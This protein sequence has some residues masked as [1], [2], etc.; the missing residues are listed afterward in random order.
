[1]V[2]WQNI[3][4]LISKLY[5]STQKQTAVLVCL[6]MAFVAFFYGSDLISSQFPCDLIITEV[7]A[8]RPASPPVFYLPH[9]DGS[10][11]VRWSP[12]GTITLLTEGF[13][14]AADP[15]VSYNGKKILFAGKRQPRD[16]WN[17]WEMDATG[18]NKRQIT[19][20]LGDCIEPKYLG[21]ISLT[22][23]K[24][25]DRTRWVAF[26]STS[27]EAYEELA[28]NC[29][30]GE[31]APDVNRQQTSALYIQNL[32]AVAGQNS[33]TR[34]LTY[35]L[36]SDFSLCPLEDG[37]ILYTSH[38][39]W[40]DGQHSAG[41]FILMAC[42][43]DGAGAHILCGE[44][45]VSRMKTM[46]CEMPDHT[47][48]FVESERALTEE[49]GSLARISLKHPWDS[50]ESLS[51]PGILYLHPH[52]LPDGRLLVACSVNYK[53]MGIVIF[54]FEKRALEQTIVSLPH[55]DLLEAIPLVPHPEP[56]GQVASSDWSDSS[57]VLFCSNVYDSN[58][59][60]S[61]FIK[62]GD[63]THVRLLEGVSQTHPPDLV[64][65]SMQLTPLPWRK[66]R[67]LEEIA[68]DPTGSFCAQVPANTPLQIQLLNA[69]GLALQ[70]I[71][72]WI[73]A[74]PGTSVRCGGCHE[75]Q[76]QSY[77]TLAKAASPCSSATS[78]P[79]SHQSRSVDFKHQVWP[80]MK[81]HCASCHAGAT[82]AGGLLLYSAVKETSK[83]A[84]QSLLA[85][86]TGRMAGSMGKYIYPGFS[87]R[88]ILA[89]LFCSP[90]GSPRSG[91]NH[92]HVPLSA[93]DQ[94]AIIEWID[95]GALWED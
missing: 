29:N 21:V 22:Q 85:P 58:T 41:K 35:N 80:I 71:P 79:Y 1:M 3:E 54:D 59:P 77:D 72:G 4:F 23:I 46:A 6:C 20:N 64:T 28:A 42:N 33:L 89:R 40:A 92:P 12:N 36:S 75:K 82:P 52:S 32:D 73:W 51:G 83:Q 17:I 93:A 65:S 7:A 53:P 69:H 24:S 70:T 63:I 91:I 87:Y 25:N 67:I 76:W 30:Y 19:A 18:L 31:S 81:Q 86:Q 84:Y 39:P 90:E 9:P 10:R 95:L 44:E 8:D 48:V 34:R 26:I 74:P 68:V 2:H 62:H 60:M 14:A 11:I 38:Q 27:S 66:T 15:V 16:F 55:W 49:G 61:H 94:K 57:A 50:L 37:R 13:A 47:V 78:L 5:A 88:S 56:E 43:G 45:R